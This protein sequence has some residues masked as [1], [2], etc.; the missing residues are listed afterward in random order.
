MSDISILRIELADIE[1]LI[2]RRIA[3]RNTTDLQT[4]HHIIQAA[5]GWLDSH[6]WEFE[7][8]ET[9][10]GRPDPDAAS[11]GHVVEPA[12]SAS[13]ARIIESGATSFGYTYD[14]GDHWE[15]L[16][17]I[18]RLENAE[19][20]ESYPLYLGGERR[21]PPED[22]GGVPGYYEFIDIISGPDKGKGSRKKKEAL[23]W[24]G[25]P[26]DPDVIDEEQIRI[27]LGRIVEAARP[28]ISSPLKP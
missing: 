5:M 1:P 8:D 7:V 19:A 17:S 9:T 24:Y 21:C 27:S 23:N 10:Y 12:S 4:L 3:V 2:W 11:W 20:G 16:I 22:C 15:H 28:P 25:R 26:Y 6:L 18:E 13:L 14:M